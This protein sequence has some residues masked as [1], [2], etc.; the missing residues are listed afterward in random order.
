[1]LADRG[2]LPPGLLDRL[3]YV[4]W[5]G[6]HK[7]LYFVANATPG[8]VILVDDDAG[9][10]RPD[11]QSRWVSIAAWDGEPDDELS[12]VRSLLEEELSGA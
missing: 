4:G 6:E 1:M 11:Q 8:E 10:V 2:V 9:W 12:R 5:S 7:D 3:E